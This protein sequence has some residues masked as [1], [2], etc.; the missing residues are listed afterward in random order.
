MIGL[1]G[2]LGWFGLGR[3]S[4]AALSVTVVVGG[5]VWLLR[6]PPPTTE[7]GLPMATST[8]V[9]TTGPV[10]VPSNA[11]APGGGNIPDEPDG[12]GSPGEAMI[13]VHVAG[14][15]SR[16]GV[17]ELPAGARVA[18]AIGA[19]GGLGRAADP[20]GLNLAARLADGERVYVPAT[21]EVDPA[22]VPA[23]GAPSPAG[24]DVGGGPIDLNE[25]TAGELETLPGVGPATAAAIV[26]D[27]AR[28]GPFA[29][30]DDLDRVP[31]IGPVRL[32][33]LAGL[34]SV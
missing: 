27:R 22:T 6:A 15:V 18:D 29:S 7:A 2:W 12:P 20:D 3:L 26:D 28:N 31:G 13:T 34:V 21:G 24:D 30:V 4:L 33:T 9:S 19:A 23:G 17:H 25:A 8:S 10:E 32:A 5:A 14:N 1:R 16:P 11:V